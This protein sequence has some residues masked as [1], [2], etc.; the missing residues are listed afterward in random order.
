MKTVYEIM[1][2]EAR[3]L[4]E[5]LPSTTFLLATD[6]VRAGG[7]CAA[8]K[9]RDMGKLLG[10]S[11]TRQ[12]D[13]L[14]RHTPGARLAIWS[15]MLDPHHNAHGDYYLVEGD[16]TGS[17]DHVP[18]DLLIA[19]WGGAPCEDSLRFFADRGSPTLIAS[20]YD[21]NDLSSVRQWM[22][23]ARTTDHVAGYMYTTWQRKYGLLEDFGALVAGD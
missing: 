10:E 11:I 18:D 4:A 19:V 20:Y 17:W 9:G 8:C 2:A 1:D 16:F 12:A 3:L 6:E 21:A 14:R 7:S 13:I 22:D 5:H 15:D 23:A